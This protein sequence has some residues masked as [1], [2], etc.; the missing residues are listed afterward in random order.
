MLGPGSILD[1]HT[2]NESI[3]VEELNQS[4]EIYKKLIHDLLATDAG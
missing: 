2:K 4:V 3:C 1:A